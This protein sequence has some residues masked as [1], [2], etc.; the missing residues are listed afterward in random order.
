MSKR[1]NKTKFGRER[2][3]RTVLYKALATALIN[4][5]K[6]KTT[7][8]KAKALSSFIDKLIAKAAIGD[9]ASRK[10]ILKFIDEKA[11]KKLVSEIGPKFKET[12]GGYTRVIRLGQRRSDGAPMAL[13][14]FTS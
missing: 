13:I 1:G 4:N 3:Q 12:K 9:L 7:Q 8:S 14:E 5:G 6:I 2:N 10:F 11:T